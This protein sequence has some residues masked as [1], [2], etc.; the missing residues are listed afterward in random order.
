VPTAPPAHDDPRDAELR[1]LIAAGEIDRATGDAIRTYGPELIG[2]LCSIFASDA[3]AHE[4]F[5]WMSEELW[6][7]FR[8]F[9]G[10]CSV[11]TWCYML[12]RHAASRVRGRPNAA[13]ELL[14]SSIP[15]VAHAA[16]YAWSTTQRRDAQAADVYAEIRRELDDDDQL[17]LVLRVDRDLAW[18]DIAIVMLGEDAAADDVTRKAATLRK[19]F[20]RVKDR[21]R[22]LAAERLDDKQ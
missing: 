6:R 19:Q 2:W 14:V 21:L 11:R 1:A 10:R 13:R 12:A 20:E 16:T 8:R 15:S 22:E 4:A 18:R 5:S 17:L 7:S 3:D 9:D